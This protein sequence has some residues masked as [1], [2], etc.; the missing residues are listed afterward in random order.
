MS[1]FTHDKPRVIFFALMTFFL[2][3][4]VGILHLTE[5]EPAQEDAVPTGYRLRINEASAADLELLPGVGDQTARSITDRRE[6]TGPFHDVQDLLHIRGI[7]PITVQR[8]EP[9]VSVE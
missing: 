9:H 8:V 6:R 3:C 2:W 5:P 4:L 7:G 1:R